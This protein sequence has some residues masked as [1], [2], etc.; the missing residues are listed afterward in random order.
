MEEAD[1]CA[2]W[3]YF[4]I[5]MG[6]FKTST[7]LTGSKLFNCEVTQSQSVKGKQASQEFPILQIKERAK[8][9]YLTE[10]V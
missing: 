2:Y 7:V 1:C 8:T 4:P 6:P 10:G 3:L 9:N 5:F